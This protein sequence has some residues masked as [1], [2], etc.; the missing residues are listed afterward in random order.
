VL[1]ENYGKKYYVS[2]YISERK[3]YEK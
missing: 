2:N 3:K 1:E